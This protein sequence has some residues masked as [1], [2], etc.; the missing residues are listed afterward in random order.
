[1]HTHQMGRGEEE[2]W[3]RRRWQGNKVT[4]RLVVG[5]REGEEAGEGGRLGIS[6]GAPHYRE[7][8]RN[9]CYVSTYVHNNMHP[10]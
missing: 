3:W 2:S 1:M 8:K 6:R 10:K 5:V 4:G 9:M 7:L